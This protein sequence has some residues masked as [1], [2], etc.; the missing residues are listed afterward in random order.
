MLL[1]TFS[2]INHR[3]CQIFGELNLEFPNINFSIFAKPYTWISKF[4]RVLIQDFERWQDIYLVWEMQVKCWISK[5]KILNISSKL[6][7][8]PSIKLK[9]LRDGKIFVLFDILKL[10]EIE[11]TSNSRWWDSNPIWL[12]SSCFWSTIYNL[13]FNSTRNP[14]KG[15]F[16]YESHIIHNLF[17]TLFG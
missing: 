2:V 8:V 1:C 12:K 17:K 13:V 16:F 3:S 7:L 9:T 15:L 5:S 10:G 6:S 4:W 14:G 11:S